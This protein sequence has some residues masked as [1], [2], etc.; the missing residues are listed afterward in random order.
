MTGERLL[1]DAEKCCDVLT[2]TCVRC[3]KPQE[4][5]IRDPDNWDP[6]FDRICSGCYTDEELPPPP[7]GIT[8]AG[9]AQSARSYQPFAPGSPGLPQ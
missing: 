3:H 6:N 4:S 2:W 9:L 7:W 5:E 1:Y 8:D